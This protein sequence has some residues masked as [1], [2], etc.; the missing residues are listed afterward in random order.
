MISDMT[1]DYRDLVES[2]KK[3]LDLQQKL[4]K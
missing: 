3:K 1:Y 2:N 4:I